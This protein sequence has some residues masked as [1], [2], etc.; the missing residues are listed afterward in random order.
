[1]KYVQIVFSPTGGTLKAANAVTEEWSGSVEVID[2]SDPNKNFSEYSFDSEDIALI[3]M[4]SYGG[5]VPA[6]AAERLKKLK[7][8]GAKCTLLCVYGNRA[9]EDTL[10]EMEDIAKEC[11]FEVKAAIAAVAEHSIAHKYAA[12]RPDSEDIKKLKEF[13]GAAIRTMQD[14][15]HTAELKLAG[16]RPYKKASGAGL[17]PKADQHCVKCG[18]CAQK[19][20]VK[21][22]STETVGTADAKKCI[23][24]M[25]CI[26]VCPHAARSANKAMV[27]A[28][29]LVL[30]K[31]ALKERNAN[32][33]SELYPI[34]TKLRTA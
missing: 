24:C 31:A 20:P 1:M 3:A 34:H 5:R 12:G 13:S 26:K 21:A 32:C 27:S 9:Y 10:V 7:G 18:V 33:L 14:E 15:A 23:S 28:V 29:S 30:K 22:I 25:R 19:C 11:G 17:V 4:P 8:G 16:N 6:T 2:L